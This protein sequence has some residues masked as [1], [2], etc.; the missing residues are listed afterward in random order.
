MIT[1]V[2]L[3]CT[4]INWNSMSKD[5]LLEVFELEYYS[6]VLVKLVKSY[7]YHEYSTQILSFLLVLFIYLLPWVLSLSMAS[8]LFLDA[9]KTSPFILLSLVLFC[10]KKPMVL[11]ICM[12]VCIHV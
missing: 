12:Y 4:E 1:K 5:K 3:V 6:T 7:G 11:I 8:L 2:A 9:N 10:I